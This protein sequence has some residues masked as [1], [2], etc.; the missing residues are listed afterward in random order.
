MT[1]TTLRKKARNGGLTYSFRGLV[2]YH[3][4]KEHGGEGMALAESYTLI[5]R[6]KRNRTLLTI[7]FANLNAHP[8]EHT[9]P[10]TRPYLLIF[11][12]SLKS[13]TSW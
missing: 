2:H 4:G 5:C 6:N 8:R 11:L 12:I 7:D 9:L 3:H 1:K 13:F 10:S